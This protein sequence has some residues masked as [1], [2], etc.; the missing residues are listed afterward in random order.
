VKCAVDELAHRTIRDS[1]QVFHT[2]IYIQIFRRRYIDVLPK[3]VKAYNETVHSTTGMAPSRVT[4]ADVL[5]I[6]R[7]LEA[8][9]QR[10]RVAKDKFRVGQHVRISK[11]KMKFA[12]AADHNFSTEIYRIIKIMDRRPVYELEDLNCTPIHGQFD[13]VELTHIRITSRTTYK[14]D[15]ILDKR[16]RRGIRECVVR[17]RGYKQDFDTWVPQ[18]V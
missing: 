16:V 8:K 15:K 11:E 12:T 1:F 2:Q 13:Q 14:D 3:F 7:R 6:W 5:A 17:W 4:E 10:V 9:K 18:Q